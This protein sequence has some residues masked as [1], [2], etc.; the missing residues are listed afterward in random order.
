MYAPYAACRPIAMPLQ[1]IFA[2]DVS[3]NKT[4]VRIEAPKHQKSWQRPTVGRVPPGSA[5]CGRLQRSPR[6]LAAGFLEGTRACEPGEER[7]R[8]EEEKGIGKGKRK[9]CGL[10]SNS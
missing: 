5:G 1:T 9:E 7:K 8:D 4:N 3:L 2:I 6:C 10:P